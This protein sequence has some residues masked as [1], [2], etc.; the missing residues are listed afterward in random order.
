MHILDEKGRA[1]GFK[2]R[3]GFGVALQWVC[4]WRF[5]MSSEMPGHLDE[6]GRLSVQ[7]GEF[8]PDPVRTLKET[9]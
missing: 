8:A 2:A 6:V 4:K 1:A 5:W 9:S 3:D 7:C